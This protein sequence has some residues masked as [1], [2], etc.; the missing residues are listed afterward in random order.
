MLATERLLVIEQ[1]SADVAVS[2][3]PIE[4]DGETLRLILFLSDGSNLRITE[5]WQGRQLLRY[6][7]Y[8]LTNQSQLMIGWDNAP[9]HRHITT[10]PHHKHVGQQTNIQSSTETTLEAVLTVIRTQ[11]I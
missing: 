11:M 2:I 1:K 10:H 8:W 6:S 5:Q 4:L 3:I 7:Y 9:H